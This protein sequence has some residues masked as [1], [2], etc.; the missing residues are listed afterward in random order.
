MVRRK[1]S[2]DPSEHGYRRFR[3]TDLESESDNRMDNLI[4]ALDQTM[5]KSLL[6]DFKS[7]IRLN[8]QEKFAIYSDY[9]LGDKTK[10]NNVAAFTVAPA[11]TVFPD[12]ANHIQNA[13]PRDIKKRRGISP[14][15]IELLRNNSFFHINFIINDD[16]GLLFRKNMSKE[17]AALIAVDEA[18]KLIEGWIIN[19]PEGIDKFSEQSYRFCQWRLELQKKSPNLKLYRQIVLISLLAGYIA[20]ML[21]V[22][23]N[24]ETVV[25]FSHRDKITD[26]YNNIAF[27]LFEINHFGL[28]ESKGV[29]GS[30]T[31]IGLGVKD[32]DSNKL[33]Y[34]PLIR[35][36][37]HLA[38]TLSSWDMKENRVSKKK[39][40]QMLQKVFSGNNFCAVIEINIGKEKIAC[41]R[42]DIT[43]A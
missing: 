43:L 37:D 20:H 26:S 16:S 30:I 24:A 31:K 32:D 29:D 19:Q 8:N 15:T 12:N 34:E 25:W 13:I 6:Q 33:W 27:D 35:I 41:G 14:E 38:G 17:G 40:A 39:H 7:Y 10:P 2:G 11:W 28:C 36:P 1:P 3:L 18:I 23:A 5:Q 42:R 21:T 9:C 4:D 22:E